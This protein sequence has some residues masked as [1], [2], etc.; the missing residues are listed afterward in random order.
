MD[1]HEEIVQGTPDLISFPSPIRDLTLLPVDRS[2]DADPTHRE[3]T[4]KF[5]RF[6]EGELHYRHQA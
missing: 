6:S 4:Y 5:F 1:G 3:V 2:V